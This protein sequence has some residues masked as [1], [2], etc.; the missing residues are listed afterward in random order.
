MKVT[1]MFHWYCKTTYNFRQFFPKMTYNLG[2]MD[3]HIVKL[4]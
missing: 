3:G 4:Y 2:R 1:L